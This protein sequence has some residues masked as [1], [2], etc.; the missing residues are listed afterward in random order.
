M[1]ATPA[2][3]LD[4]CS[5]A[6]AR[7]AV[8][9][10]HYSRCMPTPP[11]VKIGVWEVGSFVGCILFSRGSNN[12]QLLPYGL[13]QTEGCE[14]TRVALTTHR[15]A[16]SRLLAIA[17]KLLRTIATGLRLIVSYAD[18]NHRHHGGIYQAAGWFY[19]GQTAPDRQ[20]IDRAGRVWHRRQVS[21]TGVKR[22]YGSRRQVPKH[23]DCLKVPLQ[24]K[25]RYVYPL[26]AAMRAQLL[27]LAQPY[28]K[29][30]PS[31]AGAAPTDLAGEGG[32]SPTGALQL[33]QDVHYE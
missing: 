14:L 24:G 20:Y 11:L 23:R 4:W 19:M 12:N 17:I 9:H 25:H 7:Y 6:A 10:W 29:R 13:Q 8:E 16:V 21:H 1:T 18:P 26:D 27:P 30:A 31:S 28:P 5:H 32:S 2:L 33:M 15:T 3:R 22:Q